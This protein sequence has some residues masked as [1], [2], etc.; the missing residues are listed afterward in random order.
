M[1]TQKIGAPQDIPM[2]QEL[3]CH[4]LGGK[5]AQPRLNVTKESAALSAQTLEGRPGCSP[6][7]TH[8]WHPEAS[9]DPLHPQP[10]RMPSCAAPPESLPELKARIR[11]AGD[12]WISVFSEKLQ[13]DEPAPEF[14]WPPVF[15]IPESGRVAGS[16]C[17]PRGAH[18]C[19]GRLSC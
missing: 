11:V 10:L 12:S 5:G 7:V 13:L 17:L 9:R 6:D 14:N 3:V 4:S 15:E 2:P 16:D 8:R 1:Q 18:T 19:R